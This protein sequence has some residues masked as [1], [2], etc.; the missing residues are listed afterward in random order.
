M[1]PYRVFEVSHIFVCILIYSF[2]LLLTLH[3]DHG[4]RIDLAQRGGSYAGE[5]RAL[6]YVS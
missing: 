1:L 4:Y 5:V 3:F 2:R 6:L